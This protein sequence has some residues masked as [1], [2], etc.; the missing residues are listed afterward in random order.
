MFKINKNN[1]IIIIPDGT[2]SIKEMAFKDNK[3]VEEIVIPDSVTSIG[4]EAFSSCSSLR[5]I[6]MPNGSYQMDSNV[7]ENC[8]SLEDISLG[9]IKTIPARAFYNC[10]N[11]KHVELGEN[12]ETIFN[13]A[14]YNCC[15]L[16]DISFPESLHYISQGA[17]RHCGK[18]KKLYIP[19]YLR[20]ANTAFGYM[21]S[22]EE[23]TVSPDNHFYFTLDNKTL[24]KCAYIGDAEQ[25][26]LSKYNRTFCS[27]SLYAAG[28]KDEVYSF[29]KLPNIFLININPFAFS[30]SKY[31]KEL[32]IPS[33]CSKAYNNSF[34][35]CPNLENLTIYWSPLSL[36]LT[37]HNTTEGSR[38][39]QEKEKQL[40]FSKTF[41]IPFKRLIFKNDTANAFQLQDYDLALFTNIQEIYLPSNG[42]VDYSSFINPPIQPLNIYVPNSTRKIFTH[43]LNPDNR[44]I[45]EDGTEFIGLMEMTQGEDEEQNNYQIYKTYDYN[46]YIYCNGKLRI[47]PKEEI[48][49]NCTHSKAIVNI[50]IKYLWAMRELEK[51]G[52]K[53]PYLRD[54]ALIAKLSCENFKK[55]L[56]LVDINDDYFGWVLHNSCLLENIAT[57]PLN[58]RLEDFIEFVNILRTHNITDIELC[59]RAFFEFCSRNTLI[60]LLN[61]DRQLLLDVIRKSNLLSNIYSPYGFYEKSIFISFEKNDDASVPYNESNLLLEFIQLIKKTN[62]R[63]SLLWHDFVISEARNPLLHKLFK[64]YDGNI[65]RVLKNKEIFSK[66]NCIVSNNV[67]FPDLLKLLEITGAI[68]DDPTYR[69]RACN[70]IVEKMFQSPNHYDGND[71]HIHFNF[72]SEIIREEFD[73]DFADFFMENYEKIYEIEKKKNGFI[74]SIY[75]E[76]PNIKRTY[77]SNHGN[78]RRLKV[79][80]DKCIDYLNSSK[81]SNI[82]EENRELAVLIGKWYS[83][84]ETWE[85]AKQIKEEALKAPRNIFVKKV[86][87]TDGTTIWDNSP[88]SDLKEDLHPDFSFEWLPKQDYDNFILGKYCNCCAHLEGAGEGIMRSS[89]ILD[90]CQNLVIRDEK[91]EIIAKSTIFVNSD[92]GYA[93]F[94]NVEISDDKKTK[95]DKLKVYK[96]F[97]RGTKAFLDAYNENNSDKPITKVTVGEHL[98]DLLDVLV[99]ESHP[100]VKIMKGLDFDKYYSLNRGTPYKGDWQE[101][102]RLVMIKK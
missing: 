70:F 45:L 20:F 41:D 29:E 65:R 89:M 43:S 94:N 25:R 17:F 64:N 5:K 61:E 49:Q 51:K 102:Q 76:F 39:S 77:T 22:L 58:T 11:L 98:N 56:E 75:E 6:K 96:A 14:F 38:D 81:F 1:K 2:T 33:C 60:K 99:Q 44:I 40:V 12:L 90:N 16:E 78:Q 71:I 4:K 35:D 18:I 101:K 80:V 23:I 67:I 10:T 85:M 3:V 50:P 48:E 74:E 100:S 87:N 21:D 32:V 57:S 36:G 62:V 30:G 73:K 79:T 37:F 82:E 19:E 93:V 69:Q 47:L 13:D 9:K 92:E 26:I 8:S 54:G 91:G 27:V 66:D 55:L 31:L 46:Y 97:M 15:S 68:S 42:H 59:H 88:S 86:V 63:D 52:H 34:D 53:K 72:P 95:E 7:F 84:D 83:K 28:N 24:L